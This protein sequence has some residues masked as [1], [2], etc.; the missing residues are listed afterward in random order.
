[1]VTDQYKVVAVVHFDHPVTYTHDIRNVIDNVTNMAR[2]TTVIVKY[3]KTH[4]YYRH[5]DHLCQRPRDDKE[6]TGWWPPASSQYVR[7]GSNIR[8]KKFAYRTARHFTTLPPRPVYH[9]IGAKMN[10]I[11]VGVHASA[12]GSPTRVKARHSWT[13]AAERSARTDWGL[14][15]SL[16]TQIVQ[17]LATE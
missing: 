6:H 5:A 17:W 9:K 8:R 3:E 7:G 11:W 4:M 13:L 10:I 16:L 12:I 14:W 2:K 15:E 1:M